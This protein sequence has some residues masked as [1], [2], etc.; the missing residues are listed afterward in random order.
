[1]AGV[2]ALATNYNTPNF[3]GDLFRLS[4]AET[5]FFSA[6]G[7]LSG[8]KQT[9]D[10]EFEW[11]TYDFR[12][13]AQPAVLEGATA[14]TG[15]ARV[16]AQVKN[17]VQIHQEAVEISYS[18]LA[19]Y[20]RK[21][22]LANTQANPVTDEMA[23]QVT[24]ALLQVAGD[25]NYSLL[26]GAYQLPVDN[27]T[28]RKTRGI[29]S[30]ISTNAFDGSTAVN[31]GTGASATAATNL[32]TANAHGLVDGDQV[33]FTSVGTATP[34]AVRPTTWSPSSPTAGVYWV[35]SASTNT[36]AVATSYGGAAVDITA[37]GTVTVRKRLALTTTLVNRMV[38][39]AFDNGGSLDPVSAAL[40]CG[41]SQK[42]QLT[43]AYT[44]AGYVSK[45]LT[46]NVGGVTV[47]RLETDFGVLNILL[48]PDMPPDAL[49]CARLG[50]CA[51][52]YLEVP[53]RGHMF[54]EPLAKTGAS[55]RSQI[56]GEVGLEYGNQAAH[57]KLTGLALAV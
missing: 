52:V 34:L 36:F 54:I 29:L 25:V 45:E 6:I 51:P 48:D 55:D 21:G 9:T 10:T 8:G 2:T 46:G 28:A 50:Q 43:A 5:P 3:G 42:R 30:A 37:D 35:V 41:S 23:W 24:Q 17:V 39:G 26:N 19:A 14:P 40:V 20:G 16:R 32:I 53:G 49:L 47:T 56:Y 15:Q 33:V 13:R 44:A 1:M 7:G 38:Q 18:R 57:A 12:T 4:P 11:Q 27:T 31:N 22:G